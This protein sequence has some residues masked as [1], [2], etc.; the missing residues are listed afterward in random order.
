MILVLITI[1]RILIVEDDKHLGPT[2][3]KGLDEQGYA[4]TL[5]G[6][7]SAALSGLMGY[8]RDIIILD[9]GL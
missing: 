9:L 5:A 8:V 7:G 1:T 3:K 4:V 6:N 2:I